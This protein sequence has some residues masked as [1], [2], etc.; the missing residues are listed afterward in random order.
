MSLS[1][2]PPRVTDAS[3]ELLYWERIDKCSAVVGQFY[4]RS[5]F[6]PYVEHFIMEHERAGLGAEWQWS[7]AY[8][9]ANMGMRC[10][11][12]A[13]NGCAGP[14]DRPGGSTDPE[15]NIDAH[16]AEMAYYHRT[17][18]E[19]GYQLMRRVFYPSRPHDWGGGRIRKAYEKHRRYLEG[20]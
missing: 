18:G 13:R 2:C 7:A 12:R 1:A 15:R 11:F 3:G 4:P 14:M 16:V 9:G 8:S 17:K 20:R 10:N 6:Q 19:S 5:G